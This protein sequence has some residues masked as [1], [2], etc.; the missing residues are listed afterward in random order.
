MSEQ[1]MR[2]DKLQ[3]NKRIDDA[4]QFLNKHGV[5][6][7]EHNAQTQFNIQTDKGLVTYWA[8]KLKYRHDGWTREVGS[9]SCFLEDLH[10]LGFT[11]LKV[12]KKS[13]P[14]DF[15]MHQ[16][17]QL[18]KIAASY[19]MDKIESKVADGITSLATALL[20]RISDS[21]LES[22]MSADERHIWVNRICNDI[23]LLV[24]ES[25]VSK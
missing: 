20:S 22:I 24:N 15:Y 21:N 3:K 4:I 10:E 17:E 8:T 5:A 11:P 19:R 6:F 14:R 18:A 25:E 16:P 1:V 12:K 7:T 2:V 23:E 9:L 13:R